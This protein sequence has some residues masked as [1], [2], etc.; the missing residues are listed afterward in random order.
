MNTVPTIRRFLVGAGLV[1]AAVSGQLLLR[2]AAMAGAVLLVGGAFLFAVA[3]W[4]KT[5]IGPKLC[6]QGAN[7]GHLRDWITLSGLAL[8]V[9]LAIAAWLI[10]DVREP[11]PSFWGIYLSSLIAVVGIPG[12]VAV[13]N[14]LRASR[15]SRRTP[16]LYWLIA[17]VVLASVARIAGLSSLPFGTWYDEAANGLEALR[18]LNEPQYRPVYT[19]G[20]NAS[21]HYLFLIVAAFDLFGVSTQSIRLI[22]AVAGIATVAA[23]YFAGREL[24]GSSMGVIF[25][26][27]IAVS[28]W[29]VNFSRLG[30][31]NTFTPLFELLAIAFL[32]R[33]L[34]KNRLDDFVLAG[35]SLGLGFCYY[36]AFQLFAVAVGVFLIYVVI[37]HWRPGPQFW[38]GL[39]AMALAALV[40]AGPIVKYAHER[41]ES[42][43]AR[44]QNTS[45]LAGK[46]AD[47]RIPALSQNLRKHLLM[48]NV[49]GD[50]NG[51]HNL[52]GEPMLDPITGALLVL[53]IALSL[54]RWR[55]PFS[56]LLLLWFTIALMGG[57]LSLDFEAPQSLRSIA[58]LPAVYLLAVIPL[59][60]LNQEWAAGGGRYFPG[61]AVGMIALLLAPSAFYN[62]DTYFRRQAQDFASWNAF[63]TSETL[64]ARYLNA[65][66][67]DA[68][69]YVISLYDQHPTVRFLAQDVSRY[70]RLETTAFLPIV[71]PSGAELALI[72]DAERG[73]LFQQAVHVYPNAVYEEVRPPFGGPAVLYYV[74][75]PAEARMQQQGFTG[76]YV[77]VADRDEAVVQKDSEI[78]FTW[79]DDAPLSL[80]FTVEWRGVLAA[81]T[82]GPYQ[83]GLTAPGDAN[84]Y[85]DEY[86]VI[87]LEQGT[88]RG[89]SRAVVLPRG[90]HQVRVTADGG[91]GAMRLLWR[92]P[93]RETEVVPGWTVF[94]PPVTNNGLLGRYY[95]NEDWAGD[96]A[97]EQIDSRF[98]M[99]FHIPVLARPYTVEWKGKIAIPEA[100]RYGFGLK[101]NDESM[102]SINGV[103][104]VGSPGQ[105]QYTEGHSDLDAGLHDILI[106]YADRSDHTF[107]SVYWIPPSGPAAGQRQNLPDEALFPPQGDYERVAIPDLA[108][109]YPAE[110][111]AAATSQ[112]SVS[113]PVD[114]EIIATGLDQP[115]GIVSV[116]G[117]A[118]VTER[119][120]GRVIFLG[121]SGAQVSELS[122]P[123]I[124]FQEPFDVDVDERGNLYVLD[125]GTGTVSQFDSELRYIGDLPIDSSYLSRA[126]GIGLEGRG[127]LW[128]ANTPGGQLVRYD[129]D[130]GS[131]HTLQARQHLANYGEA[132]PVDVLTVGDAAIYT[133]DAG[134]HKLSRYDERG[135]R[136]WSIDI[137]EANTVHG[138]HLAA[139]NAG[140]VFM[141]EPE[142]GTVAEVGEF[143]TVV[144]RWALSTD[145][146]IPVK[147]VGLTVD[148]AGRIWVTDSDG[149]R[150]LRF[151]PSPSEEHPV[152]SD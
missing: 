123:M 118:V 86:P 126:R 75:V 113:T 68:R 59:H 97:M 66:D 150:V 28:R 152:G 93:D 50:P 11:S 80:P 127:G 102:L 128:I 64:T 110:G 101:S 109:L 117:G 92:T 144:R 140:R 94:G 69:A 54:M 124:A 137:P 49:K 84:L 20:V 78:D 122:R 91:E 105:G 8:A 145:D 61:A 30:M 46:S 33:A 72:M 120:Q 5:V 104:I 88:D 38:L 26:F 95:A 63:S 7:G 45:L 4:R 42:Y 146:E 32:I 2:D 99:Y 29:A 116:P 14:G 129:L 121:D 44:V 83:F 74:E 96:P 51:R 111:D 41:P 125:S 147:P 76:T 15:G 85:V 149:G 21:G 17:I 22:S 62:L 10:L 133:A 24:F 100:G 151:T 79:P 131:V 139:D 130:T 142:S 36:S 115:A 25:A 141:S 138:S 19:D 13:V 58:A 136:L 1:F 34:R 77:P 71:E 48:F 23:A 103:E 47:E 53:G 65:L 89:G 6:L 87:T 67:P 73:D 143:G 43:F 3:F 12:G 39:A 82:Y 60:A 27:V 148:D 57:V 108:D 16:T 18:V 31:Y 135:M 70:T 106:R 114:V 56:L 132:Q 35:V 37:T 55:Q 40:V 90:L 119:G 98:D 107:I 52:P 134:V 81:E 9:F 112:V